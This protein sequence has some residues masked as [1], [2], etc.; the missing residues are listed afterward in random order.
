MGLTGSTVA[1]VSLGSINILLELKYS[2][3]CSLFIPAPATSPGR[4][5]KIIEVPARHHTAWK[6]A[7]H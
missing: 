5:E 4:G 1:A 7:L 2:F 3:V 6:I